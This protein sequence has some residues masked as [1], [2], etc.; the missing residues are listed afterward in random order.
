MYISFIVDLWLAIP[1][2][3]IIPKMT[4][5]TRTVSGGSR[6]FFCILRF[7]I[8]FLIVP[9]PC[10][11]KGQG[12]SPGLCPPAACYLYAPA[13]RIMSPERAKY[14]VLGSI[15]FVSGLRYL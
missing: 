1:M 14:V 10:A 6:S 15:F 11:R 7:E 5:K 8:I 3:E 12:P 13:Q 9:P 4:R 2:N